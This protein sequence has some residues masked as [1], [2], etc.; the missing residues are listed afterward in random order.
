MLALDV[1][2]YIEHAHAHPVLRAAV[3]VALQLKQHAIGLRSATCRRGLLQIIH[4]VQAWVFAHAHPILQSAVLIAPQLHH[5]L[6]IRCA[7]QE[8]SYTCLRNAVVKACMC[9]CTCTCATSMRACQHTS[10][11]PSE[12]KGAKRLAY[13]EAI[14]A[15]QAGHTAAL[16]G[17]RR[18]GAVA[19]GEDRVI[20]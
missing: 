7:A 18:Q 3:L 8:T 13:A 11:V 15:A 4:S 6:N 14:S 9:G 2:Q 10:M 16:V 20:A 5:T 19:A 12:D 17:Q 1:I